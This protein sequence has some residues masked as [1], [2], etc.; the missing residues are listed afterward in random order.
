[1]SLNRQNL[2]ST[3]AKERRANIL[4]GDFQR[5]R[6]R[7]RLTMNGKWDIFALIFK[8]VG[9]PNQSPPED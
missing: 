1:M 3:H 5:G 7:R 6:N 9:K 8:P 2:L 4:G